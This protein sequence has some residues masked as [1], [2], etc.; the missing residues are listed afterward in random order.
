MKL[1]NI[2]FVAIAFMIVFASCKGNNQDSSVNTQDTAGLAAFRQQKLI[3]AQMADQAKIDSLAQVKAEEMNATKA[4][5]AAVASKS[6]SSSSSV[7]RSSSS[8]SSSRSSG[9]SSSARS[10]SSSN[11]GYASAPAQTTTQRQGISKAAKGAMIGAGTGAVAG[12]IINKRNRG[13]GAVIGG[14]VGGAAGYGIGRAQD[15]KD[16]RY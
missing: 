1:T 5:R 13:A 11:D 15:K 4:T 6:S 12:A 7:R 3:E 10:G 2:L 16:G 9:S 8:S 14:V